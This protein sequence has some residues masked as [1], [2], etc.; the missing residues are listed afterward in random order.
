MELWIIEAPGKASTL[1]ALLTRMGLE[2][3]VQ[4]TKG[5]LLSM[6]D[7]LTPLGIDSGLQEYL[8]APRDPE[9]VT[10][11][12]TMASETVALGGRIVVA[13]DADQEGDVIAW[14][15]A[16]VLSDIAPAPLRVRL[17][18][19][20]DD[21]IRE[22]VAEA[23]P[24]RQEDAIPGRTRAIVDRL[25][26]GAFSGGGVAVGRVGTALL[27]LV[28]Q[29]TPVVHRLRLSAPAKDGGRPWLA[30]CDI[31]APL[32]VLTAGRI[33][34]LALPMLD[35]K[36]AE[37]FTAAPGHMGDVMVR[38]AET[39]GLSPA[40]TARAM[41]RTYE[42]GTLSYP[43]SGS[44]GMSRA[45]ARKMQRILAKVGTRFDDTAVAEKTPEEVHDAPHPIGAI[46]LS[47]DPRKLGA[48][49]GVRALIG[50]DLVRSGQR[51]VRQ[52]ALGAPIERFLLG[53][54]FSATVARH[55]AGLDWR[56]EQGPRYP[57]Q[58]SWAAS[59]VVQRRPDA[60]L[61]EAAMEAG[62][63]RPSTWANH[64]EGFLERGLADDTLALTEKGR[65]W[66]AASP[67]VLL[68]PRISAAIERA[69]ERGAAIALTTAP[70]QEP[71]EALATHII[72]ALPPAL[73]EPVMA[74]AAATPPQP[75]PD[76]L[77]ATAV[78]GAEAKPSQAPPT[79]MR[80]SSSL[81]APR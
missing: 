62:L 67:E 45:A 35:A 28:A 58:E 77:Q 29:G 48:D 72:A 46:N 49:E 30:E 24:V 59:A 7:R 41:Q 57:G 22:A 47:L 31:R 19:M 80:R 20:D 65:A 36:S 74:T 26:G 8:R 73:R 81:A 11:L 18:G 10:R 5:H 40:Q 34:Q 16:S 66:V 21:S 2:A 56:R 13:T 3:R 53:Q 61:L 14:D 12:R 23:A 63:G 33:A 9:I 64:I 69:C 71:W 25:I 38:A 52:S 6:P 51:H 43:R 55:V 32:D 54:G 75:R 44:R 79:T 4:A 15:V 78:L 37:P 68:D 1:Q 60:A 17:R 27:G 39:L 70:G 42:A 76:P 50:R